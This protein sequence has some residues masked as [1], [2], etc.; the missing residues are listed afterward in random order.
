MKVFNSIVAVFFVVISCSSYAEDF[1]NLELIDFDGP[2]DCCWRVHSMSNPS[3]HLEGLQ[4]D[5]SGLI[6]KGRLIVEGLYLEHTLTGNAVSAYGNYYLDL[7][8]RGYNTYEASYDNDTGIY[9]IVVRSSVYD[10]ETRMGRPL[11]FK[12]EESAEVQ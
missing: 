5:G 8:I 4:Y 10:P 3:Y 6:V 11:T 9:T 2:T 7:N 1:K 12:F